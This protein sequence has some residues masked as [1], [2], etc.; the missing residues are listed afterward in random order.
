MI[1]SKQVA[2]V[3]SQRKKEYLVSSA[4]DVLGAL[5]VNFEMLTADHPDTA[6]PREIVS[7][8]RELDVGV[9]HC[10]KRRALSLAG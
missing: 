2:T 3:L 5:I 8:V 7:A 1:K 10:G 6:L 4:I 9:S